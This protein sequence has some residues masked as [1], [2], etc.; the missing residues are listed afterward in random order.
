M[1]IVCHIHRFHA[2][3][4]QLVLVLGIY[5]AIRICFAMFWYNLASF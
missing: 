1:D 5:F 2:F 4:D 3:I